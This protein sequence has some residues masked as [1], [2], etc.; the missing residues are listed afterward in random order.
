LT[1]IVREEM[2]IDADHFSQTEI[3]NTLYEQIIEGIKKTEWPIGSGSFMLK[4]GRNVNGVSP[5]KFE[6]MKHLK[7]HKWRLETPCKVATN[8]NPG[9][10]DATYPV[11]D[12][13]FCVEWETGNISSSHRSINKILLGL[14][15][16]QFIAGVLIV[17]SKEMIYYLTERI[18]NIYELEPYF[19]LF[20]TVKIDRGLFSIVAFEHDGVSTS[21]PHIPKRND[22]NSK[23]GLDQRVEN[24]GR[25]PR[26][27]NRKNKSE[28]ENGSPSLWEQAET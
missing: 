26:R 28:Q 6:C 19:P 14:V 17:P 11:E 24:L 18:G 4:D 22:G 16:K 7:E 20:R 2:L 9:P 10:I 8:V 5:I 15:L 23:E 3:W 12:K 13:L 21:I 1:K 27:K 25:S